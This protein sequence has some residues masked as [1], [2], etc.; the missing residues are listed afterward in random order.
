MPDSHLRDN[1]N[2][3]VILIIVPPSTTY[4]ALRTIAPLNEKEWK[5]LVEDLEKGQ[6]DRQAEIVRKA[7]EHVKI[8]NISYEG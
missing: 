1:S 7:T 5:L 8:L 6:T 3:G 2:V 4:M